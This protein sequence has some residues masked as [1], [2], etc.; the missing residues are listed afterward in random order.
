[1]KTFLA[2]LLT[3]LA[4]GAVAPHTL[5]QDHCARFVSA[6][7]GSYYTQSFDFSH[8]HQFAT[9]RGVKVAVIDTGVYP[10]HRLTIAHSE[11]ATAPEPDCYGHGTLVAGIIAAHNTGDGYSGI[12][13]GAEIIAINQATGKDDIYTGDLGTMAESIHRSID[14]GARII[15]ISMVGCM[16]RPRRV[17]ELEEA[18][19][20]AERSGVVVI[21]ASGNRM[22]ACP[23][24]SVAYPGYLPTVLSVQAH[25]TDTNALAS[26]SLA[27]VD[28]VVSAPGRIPVAL[29]SHGQ[30]LVVGQYE[31]IGFQGTSFA[32]PVVS[33]LAAL[34]LERHPTL[35]PQQVRDVL[36]GS[37]DASSHVIDMTLVTSALTPETLPPREHTLTAERRKSPEPYWPLVMLIGFVVV[38]SMFA[39]GS[40]R[41][42]QA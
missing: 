17:F 37:A 31:P 6:A 28:P 12:A 16:D 7:P 33:G 14:A 1:M 8:L 38:F 36:V 41:K 26:Y 24:G 30:D 4:L 35:S 11:G 42:Q 15:N 19:D 34:L 29:S 9:G 39:V 10:H 3:I 21:A 18:L 2:L 5:A 25:E 27:G 22:S 13:P 32:T 40:H 20:R 23:E